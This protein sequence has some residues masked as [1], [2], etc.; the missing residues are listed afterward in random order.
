[1]SYAGSSR[2][3]GR[4]GLIVVSGGVGFVIF[5]DATSLAFLRGVHA[6][7]NAA[8]AWKNVL[9]REQIGDD[10]INTGRS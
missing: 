7:G 2:S 6:H 4:G 5:N 3:S 8:H 10:G 1:V 9:R